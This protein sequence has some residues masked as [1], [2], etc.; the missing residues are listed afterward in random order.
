MVIASE[1]SVTNLVRGTNSKYPPAIHIE[2]IKLSVAT[3]IS[4][5]VFTG[6]N[7]RMIKIIGENNFT[8]EFMILIG[9]FNFAP[10]S[11]GKGIENVG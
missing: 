6:K 5:R 8:C 10:F 1:P 11:H 7:S 9:F 2:L 4:F 3:L